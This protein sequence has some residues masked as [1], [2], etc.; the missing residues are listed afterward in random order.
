MGPDGVN[1]VFWNP[2]GAGTR[3]YPRH[4]RTSKLVAYVRFPQPGQSHSVAQ[5][6]ALWMQLSDGFVKF[7][8]TR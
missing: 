6:P 7:C 3:G 1:R 2:S 8:F 4:D 5:D